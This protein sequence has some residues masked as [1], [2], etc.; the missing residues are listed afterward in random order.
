MAP[1]VAI[2]PRG[3][4]RLGLGSSGGRRI[5]SANIQMLL[6]IVD[7]GLSL[8]EALSAPRVDASSPRIL[9]DNRLAA[10]A[11]EDL[12]A[13]GLDVEAV[14]ESPYPRHFGSPAGVAA[15]ADG[16]RIGAADVFMPS[17]VVAL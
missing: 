11:L 7:G 1:L 14:D 17:G 5:I 16:R 12:A 13:R 2:G 3:W 10:D 6:A 15:Y 4:P 9:A 8:A